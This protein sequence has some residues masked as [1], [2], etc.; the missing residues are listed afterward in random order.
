MYHEIVCVHDTTD[1]QPPTQTQSSIPHSLQ[2]YKYAIYSKCTQNSTR[3]T[4]SAANASGL[5]CHLKQLI[6]SVRLSRKSLY[7]TLLQHSLETSEPAFHS[8]GL[9][10]FPVDIVF[11]L[12]STLLLLLSLSVTV[13]KV[14][15][16]IKNNKNM[17]K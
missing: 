11:F 10:I 14:Q 3:H 13:K 7:F 15:C 2:I 1:T 17:W 4:V 8:L 9:W 5:V 16:V 6:S 12:N